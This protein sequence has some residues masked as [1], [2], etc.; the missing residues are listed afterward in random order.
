MT[1]KH[2]KYAAYFF[3]GALDAS[4]NHLETCYE[5]MTTVTTLVSCH[6]RLLLEMVH[7]DD[8]PETSMGLEYM[9]VLEPQK[10][11]TPPLYRKML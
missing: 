3:Q 8:L 6:L 11:T 1:T 10:S 7:I 2:S 5:P 9:L 4:S